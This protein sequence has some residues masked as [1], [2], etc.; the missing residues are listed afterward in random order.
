[1]LFAD[2]YEPLATPSF[3]GILRTWLE[4]FV[5]H[6]RAVLACVDRPC[7]DSIHAALKADPIVPAGKVAAL[8]AAI[9]E[10]FSSFATCPS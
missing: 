2:R 8:A 7:L 5:Q 10:R 3:S 9:F 6:E 4:R 1:M